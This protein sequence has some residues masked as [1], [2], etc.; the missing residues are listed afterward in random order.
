MIGCSIQ[1]LHVFRYFRPNFTGEGLYF[2]KLAR[3]LAGF[4]VNSDVIV[5]T[6]CAPDAV[7]PSAGIRQVHY[8]G[9]GDGWPRRFRPAM[10][11]WLCMNA[12][13]YEVIHFHAS[14]DR[15]LLSQTIAHLLG[16]AVVQS[17][18]LD[19]G[20]GQAVD[21]Y[22]PLYRP[23]VRRQSRVID[24]VIGLSPKLHADN[25]R[26]LDAT[27]SY[28]I[29]QGVE[30][31]EGLPPGGRMDARARWGF[32]PQDI[33]MLFVGGLCARKDVGFLI[34]NHP[35]LSGAGRLRLLIV[36]PDLEDDH[37]NALRAM[38]AASPNPTDI[39][40]CG[41]MEDPSPAYQ[42]AD[43]FVFA[44]RAE[45]FGNVLIEAMAWGLPVVVRRLP[46]VTDYIVD[47]GRTGFLF[48]TEAEY[49]DAVNGLIQDA[50]QR[51]EMGGAARVH[52]SMTFGM[53]AIASQYL[54]LYRRL[55]GRRRT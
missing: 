14:V 25:L 29:P 6:T 3:H 12:R 32:G 27:R 54:A 15:L 36:G 9:T 49:R 31:P 19:D 8:F 11:R 55:A 47:H 46:G 51:R 20:L 1:V 2:E 50:T 16:C 39:V 18:T 24:A 34:A 17:T 53:P 10:L 33:V 35:K 40:L 43:I 5:D 38:A 4:G 42:A 21:G 28:L 7:E 37:A 13:R 45:G 23:I 44:S 22:R 48:N 41:Y 26:V 30:A 52:A